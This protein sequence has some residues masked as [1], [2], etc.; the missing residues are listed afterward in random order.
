[1]RRE[2]K[3]FKENAEKLDGKY[4]YERAEALY[5]EIKKRG[6]FEDN[7]NF[8]DRFRELIT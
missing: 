2:E 3:F 6:N 4:P 1:L 5:K 7:K 8:L